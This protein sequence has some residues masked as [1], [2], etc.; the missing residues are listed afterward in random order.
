MRNMSDIKND[1]AQPK[2]K[3]KYLT[4]VNEKVMPYDQ[5]EEVKKTIDYYQR[6][7]NLSFDP[8]SCMNGKVVEVFDVET[9]SNAPLIKAKTPNV[10]LAFNS[11]PESAYRINWEKVWNDVREK[12]YIE[13]DL[14]AMFRVLNKELEE[15]CI[16]YY[17]E[18]A[19][20]QY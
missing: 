8:M 5:E 10:L 18:H 19:E 13:S 12:K 16:E 11:I 1:T 6:I 2:K 9:R 4:P 3:Y 7:I 17:G 20:I 15:L 14:K